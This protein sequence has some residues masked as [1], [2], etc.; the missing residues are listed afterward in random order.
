MK[1]AARSSLV[2]SASEVLPHMFT[3]Y[4][5]N[6]WLPLWISER[7]FGTVNQDRV[8]CHVFAGGRPDRGDKVGV[9]ITEG[10]TNNSN[11]IDVEA[12]IRVVGQGHRKREFSIEVESVS[13]H[14]RQVVL[15]ASRQISA[16]YHHQ[17]QST[18][19]PSGFPLR[20]SCS[21]RARSTH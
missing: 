17:H 5:V 6:I 20:L 3:N 13:E 2:G 12:G 1:F 21:L 9:T 7:D 19:L 18:D 11:P 4:L 16:Q 10:Q 8:L 15:Q 14:P